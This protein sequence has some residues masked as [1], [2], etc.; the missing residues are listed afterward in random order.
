M[1]S[2]EFCMWL[3]G[4]LDNRGKLSPSEVSLVKDNLSRILGSSP[5][6]PSC[7]AGKDGECHWENCPQLRDGEPEQHGRHCPLPHW[8]DDPEW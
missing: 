4:Y 1:T 2:R 5:L 7:H 6:S 3:E 8:T